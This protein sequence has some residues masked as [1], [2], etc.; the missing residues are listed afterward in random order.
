MTYIDSYCIE[1]ELFFSVCD[2]CR[3]ISLADGLRTL[4][5]SGNTSLGNGG[6]L[7][8]LRACSSRLGLSGGGDSPME[9]SLIACGIES[10]LSPAFVEAVK[11]LQRQKGTG[12]RV[13]GGAVRLCK[14]DLFGN[15]I[16]QGDMA[17]LS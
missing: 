3:Y 4:D 7:R 11:V 16:D 10:P 2:H 6:A 1:V 12:P 17:L 9:L 13:G 8:L 14:V 15:L 5:V